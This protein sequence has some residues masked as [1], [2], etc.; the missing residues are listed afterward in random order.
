[1][2]IR[3]RPNVVL[4]GEMLPRATMKAAMAAA[5]TADLMLV[6]GSSLEVAPAGDLPELARANGARLILILSLIHI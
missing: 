5:R 1:M 3:D 2:C 6:A 4:F